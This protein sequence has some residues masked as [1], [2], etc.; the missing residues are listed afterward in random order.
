MANVETRRDVPMKIHSYI[1]GRWKRV[2]HT[3]TSS[4]SGGSTTS[5]FRIEIWALGKILGEEPLFGFVMHGF[6]V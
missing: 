5:L 3:N 1:L 6:V 2:Q 4:M